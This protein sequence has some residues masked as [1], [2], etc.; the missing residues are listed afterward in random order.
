MVSR[1]LR[2][3]YGKPTIDRRIDIRLAREWAAQYL[4]TRAP[5]GRG[6]GAAG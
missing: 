4:E 6:A 5:A 1:K 3:Y 2:K